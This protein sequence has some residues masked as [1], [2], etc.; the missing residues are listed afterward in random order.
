MSIEIWRKVLPNTPTEYLPCD[1]S[2]S[3]DE[4]EESDSGDEEEEQSEEE[5]EKKGGEEEEEKEGG[6]EEEEEKKGGEEEEEENKGG[7]EEEEEKGGEEEEEKGGVFHKSTFFLIPIF[8]KREG[9]ETMCFNA[10][11]DSFAIVLI[12]ARTILV[13]LSFRNI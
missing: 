4:D 10:D 9:N 11:E 12:H 7:E 6:E 3:G 1:E 8:D 5:E 2:D 13:G